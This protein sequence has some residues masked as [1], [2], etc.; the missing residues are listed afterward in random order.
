MSPELVKILPKE[1]PYVSIAWQ[2]SDVCNYRCSYCSEHN[3][4][5]KNKN[6]NKEMI[7]KNLKTIFDHYKKL[8]YSD[9][10]IFFS[11]GEP[12][13]W[14]PLLEVIEFAKSELPRVKFAIN[15]NLSRDLK[16]WEQN[17]THFDD[18]VC[19]FHIEGANPEKFIETYKFLQDK[20]NYLVARM[21]MHEKRFSEVLN[22]RD[23]LKN[24]AFNYKIEYVPLYRELSNKTEPWHYEDVEQQK[25]FE[26]HS[27]ENSKKLEVLPRSQANTSSIEVY[28]DGTK[29]DLN[30]NRLV[31]E[32]KNFYSGWKCFIHENIY[33]STTGE[34]SLGS[35]GQMPVIGNLYKDEIKLTSEPV[36]CKKQQCHCGTD[37][38]ITKEQI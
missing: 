25:F 30:S 21:M 16:W 13:Y 35:C 29:R 5:G 4:G 32:R 38:Y 31:A 10:K 22:F 19:S 11:G 18:I 12:T 26:T 33:V 3:W 17:H 20:T 6:L 28:S 9:Y 23:K 1:R 27:F 15:T 2:V 36:I 34:L 24:E 37:I 7:K 14:E 8:N